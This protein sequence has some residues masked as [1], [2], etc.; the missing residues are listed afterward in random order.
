MRWRLKG[1][2][3]VGLTLGAAAAAALW[4]RAGPAQVER[5]PMGAYGGERVFSVALAGDVVITKSIA[6]QEDP[7]FLALLAPIREA[8]LAFADLETL[9][10]DYEPWAEAQ[11]GGLGTYLRADPALAEELA[12]AG[13]DLVSMANDHVADYGAEGMRLT[14]G[15]VEA[16]GL[17]AAGTGEDLR[18]ARE[19]RFVETHDGRV[20]LV[21]TSAAFPAHARAG[22][23]RGGVRGRPG[24]SPLR[25]QDPGPRTVDPADLERLRATLGEIGV[26]VTRPGRP[27]T[28]FGV[29]L[30]PGD[31]ESRG[32][33]PHE[34]DVRE[35]SAVVRSASALSD[36]VVLSVHAHEHGAWLRSFAHAMIDEGADV[37]VGHGTHTVGGIEIH[38][39]RP[40]FYSLGDFIFQEETIDALP[41]DAY[42]RYG[43]GPD[44]TVADFNA[45]RTGQETSDYES[46]VAVP[47]FD[48]GRLMSI[49][50]YPV[51]LGRDGP[52]SARGVPM[53]AQGERGRRIVQRVAEMSRGHGTVVVWEE[54]RG[55]GVVSVPGGEGR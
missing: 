48:S 13:I 53:L 1:P 40:I 35:I 39:G 16:A 21:A 19:A 20:A 41:A 5:P 8:D 4:V 50:L 11:S 27:L 52:P 46:V 37:V 25:V 34:T 55:I 28:A 30:A 51:T 14:R 17:L 31:E 43:L 18:E 23:P 38:E 49:E 12:W 15:Y 2:G 26:E 3:G 9:F 7:R 10:H 33:V 32:G 29:E 54:G 22:P 44:A 45:A 47:T 42:A 6:A 24:L 36:Y